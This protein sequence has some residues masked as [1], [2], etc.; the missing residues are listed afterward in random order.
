MCRGKQLTFVK[1]MLLSVQRA[2]VSLA[3][4]DEALAPQTNTQGYHMETI[5][6]LMWYPYEALGHMPPPLELVQVHQSGNFYLRITP[7]G[8][9]RLLV[10]TTRF[11]VPATDSRSLKLA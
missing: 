2:F 10:N 11:S 6:A 5:W 8:S 3:S 7:V 9:G 1:K 4:P